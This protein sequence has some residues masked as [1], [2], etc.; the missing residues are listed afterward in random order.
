ML[1]R[2]S[3]YEAGLRNAANSL[4]IEGNWGCYPGTQPKGGGGETEDGTIYIVTSQL[5]TTAPRNCHCSAQLR[6]PLT[7]CKYGY[8][9]P[10]VVSSLATGPPGPRWPPAKKKFDIYS[11]GAHTHTPFYTQTLLHT[12]VFTQRLLHTDSF[13]TQKLLHTEAFTHIHFHTQTPLHT[14]TFTHRRFHTQTL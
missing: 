4:Q 2:P 11:D 7:A 13:Y 12:D 6:P 9:G 3:K 14:D 8:T 1:Q 10:G 5:R